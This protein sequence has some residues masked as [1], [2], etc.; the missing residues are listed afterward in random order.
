M[1]NILVLSSDPCKIAA[2]RTFF[3]DLPDFE[4]V[5]AFDTLR[6]M[7]SALEKTPVQYVFLDREV[8]LTPGVAALLRPQ[9]SLFP[10]LVVLSDDPSQA[11]LAFETPAV[12]D[13]LTMPVREGRLAQCAARLRQIS[14]LS[15][16]YVVQRTLSAEAP[17]RNYVFVKVNKR[18]MRLSLDDICYVESVKDYVKIVCE[19][20]SFLVYN[21][22]SNFT[23]SLPSARFF[24]IHRS[25]TVAV[26]KI[27]WLDA[28]TVEVMGVRLPVTKKYL[29]D[30]LLK[31]M[32]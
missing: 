4:I 19:K 8:A 15:E 23:A 10:Y 9:E 1:K 31:M 21:T 29:T 20:K 27:D 5:G 25:Y 22:L 14:D 16:A 2:L 32:R 30:N 24:R 13:F 11:A 7:L 3:A 17:G 6:A 28:S 18:Y 26:D 12:V